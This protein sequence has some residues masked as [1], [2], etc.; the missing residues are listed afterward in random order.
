M[1]NASRFGTRPALL[2]R[3]SLLGLAAAGAICAQASCERALTLAPSNA[4]ISLMADSY[5]LAYNSSTTI[6]AVV[7]DSAG[8]AVADGTLVSFRSSLGTVEPTTAYTGNGRASVRLTTGALSGTASVSASSGSIQASPLQLQVGML[9]GR[10]AMTSTPT[11]LN[12]SEVTATLFDTAGQVLSGASVL[13]TAAAG[14]LSSP[15]VL[16]DGYGQARTTLFSSVDALVTAQ[17]G[18]LSAT[19]TA[20]VGG[21][22]TLSVNIQIDPTAPKR[23]Q[24]VTFTATVLTIGGGPALVERYEWDFGDLVMTTTGNSTARNWDTS[25]RYGVTLKV[26]GVNGA[27]GQTRYEFYVD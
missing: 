10:I 24:N 9:P 13:F 6:T 19:L 5:T 22:S 16:T 18:G 14:V 20:R 7:V 8:K 2:L 27:V 25:G 26:L 23:F 11:S 15:M 17:S 1:M 21:S 4:V 12:A 3:R